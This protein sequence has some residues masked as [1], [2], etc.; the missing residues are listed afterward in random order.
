MILQWI[1]KLRES[2]IR[3]GQGTNTGLFDHSQFQ[4][5]PYYERNSKQGVSGDKLHQQRLEWVYFLLCDRIQVQAF[6]DFL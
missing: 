1:I 6:E 4:E 2:P 3:E 5:Q